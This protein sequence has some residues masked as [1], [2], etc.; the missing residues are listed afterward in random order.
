MALEVIKQA[1]PAGGRHDGGAPGSRHVRGL[2]RS[3]GV[4]AARGRRRGRRRPQ[5]HPGPADDAA[6]PARDPRR[7]LV[8]C[9]RRSPSRTGRPRRSRRFSG[10]TDPGCRLHPGRARTSRSRSSRSCATATRSPSWARSA[11]ELG[12]R[13]LGVCCG[14]GAAPHPA[15]SPRRSAGLRPRAATR[16]TCRST[17]SSAARTRCRRPT[18]EY[19]KRL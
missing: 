14:A 7:R 4:Q 16:P 9:R 1:R 18:E 17:R 10:L 19:A 3:G 6:R 13:Y 15:R 12:I 2:E 5:L 8:P 11:Y